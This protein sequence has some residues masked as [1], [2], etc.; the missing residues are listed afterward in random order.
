MSE[1]ADKATPDA[2]TSDRAVEA[3][4]PGAAPTL[5]DTFTRETGILLFALGCLFLLMYFGRTLFFRHTLAEH[6]AHWPVPSLQPYL[7]TSFSSVVTRMIMPLAFIT[8]VL[9]EN[10]LDFGFRPRGG[11]TFLLIY[12]G[13][14]L[15]MVPLLWIVAGTPAFQHKYPFWN[16]AGD[17]WRNLI[18]YETRY[19]FVFLSGESFWRGFLV[20]GLAKRFGWH[21][22]SIAMVPY[23]MVH[24][25]KPPIE[26]IGAVITGYVLGYLALKH[27]SFW[28]GV[29]LHFTIA[30]L[31]D[32]FSL[33]RGPGLP[34]SW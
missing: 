29:I 6:F 2:V 12:A 34:A 19:F 30:F 31:M 5:R 8:L 25:G 16:E 1:A 11:R 27:R 4:P 10:P 28:L 7:W 14:L 26:T 3:L 23:V 18:L 20:F 9:R 24:F 32:F 33:M 22:L 15:F 21:A 13:L 17:S